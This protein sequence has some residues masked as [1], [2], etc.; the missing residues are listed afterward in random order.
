MRPKRSHSR[1]RHSLLQPTV[2]A[3]LSTTSRNSS[4]QQQIVQQQPISQQQTNNISP[5]QHYTTPQDGILPGSRLTH[6]Y[7]YWTQITSHQW[8]WSIVKEGY[9]IQFATHPT[10]W[11]INPLSLNP[12]DQQ[13]A[14]EAVAKF[15]LA[16]IIELMPTQSEDYL[17]KFFTN[18]T[19][20]NQTLTDIELSTAESTH[21]MRALQNG[22]RPGTKRGYRKRRFYVQDRL[23]KT[24][25]Q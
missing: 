1:Q 15:L 7:N 21:P 2:S 13:A 14:N 9:K 23:K 22:R 24:P 6:F 20:K 3:A 18:H 19:R 10:P 4:Q 25:I 5:T 12:T 17:S 16:R 8:P 11:K